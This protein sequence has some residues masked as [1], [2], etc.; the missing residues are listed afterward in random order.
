MRLITVIPITKGFLKK[1]LSYFTTKKIEL[2]SIVK[3]PIRKKTV[4]AIVVSS[5]EIKEVKSSLKKSSFSLKKIS[6]DGV[7]IFNHLFIDAT[8]E[9]A[10]YYA[11]SLSNVLNE[12]T[13]T[14]I[15]ENNKQLEKIGTTINKEKNDEYKK[16]SIF[17]G[18]NLERLKYYRSIVREE[19]AK[20]RSVLII[21]PT[22]SAITEISNEL[23]KGIESHTIIFHS[24]VP[25]KRL[26]ELWNEAITS[27]KP[28]L[29]I[30]TGLFL[31]LPIKNLDTIIVDQESSPFY[32][33]RT[34]PY[35]DTRKVAEITSQHIKANLIY[36]DTVVRTEDYY[37]FKKE[38]INPSHILSKSEQ[39]LVN[40]KEEE[41]KTK[42]FTIISEELKKMLKE[43]SKHNEHV[44][45]FL[46]R[47][48]YSQTTI[49]DDC[50][51]TITCE[52]CDSPLVLHKKT[53]KKT[54][55][56]CHK[57]ISSFSAEDRC[58]YCKSWRL[59]SL[60]VGVER[61]A[62]EINSLFPKF[63]LF[64]M[65]SDMVKTK[66]QGEKVIG[67][68]FSMP[69]SILIA[70][71]MI[72]SYLNREIDRSAIISVDALFTIPDFRINERI[73]HLLV[74]L[75]TLSQ[76]T[77]LVQ[78][79]MPELNIFKLALRGDVS[80][81][82][83]QELDMRQR[84][85]YPPFKILIKITKQSKD[86]KQ[87]E[88]DFKKLEKELLNYIPM[89]YSAFVPKIKGMHIM[90]ALLKVNPTSWPD[91]NLLEVLNSL[92]PSWRVEV[93]PSSLL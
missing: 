91:Q 61:V 84:F 28:L 29:V 17:H 10:T 70:T 87:L 41:E 22:I 16:I 66:K 49:C 54:N 60:G 75:K 27:E 89:I 67:D 11:S 7:P 68:F 50:R 3:I 86:K 1:D 73:F 43:S 65:D 45:L 48:G 42:K 37:N 62:E 71:E 5:K 33:S 12:V 79:R 52:K 39:I 77:F 19:F 56:I 57:C 74:K 46:N 55:F 81:F 90:H 21:L 23:K 58:P 6:E 31:S 34:R 9:I 63:K 14:T 92:P 40:I 69:G 26:L 93:D 13:P 20:E 15:L 25:K 88:A 85:S 8:L 53:D 64:R 72:F 47:R 4:P 44:I 36:G 32:K 35:I 51:K 59:K 80:E 2:G 82:Y 78:T 30:S 24:E 76:K 18:S 38:S 83:R